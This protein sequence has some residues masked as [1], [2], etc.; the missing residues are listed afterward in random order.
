MYNVVKW[1]QQFSKKETPISQDRR[2]YL[3]HLLE[4][5]LE[6]RFVMLHKSVPHGLAVAD[7][8]RELGRTKEAEGIEKRLIQRQLRR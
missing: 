3:E 6:P 2:E 7:A 8:Y 4:N 5:H 1:Q